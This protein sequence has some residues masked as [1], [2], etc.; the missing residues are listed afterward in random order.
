MNKEQVEEMYANIEGTRIPTELIPTCPKCGK[1][2]KPWVRSRVFLEG[3][4]YKSELGKYEEYLMKNKDKKVLFL[5]LGVGPM[6]P[7]CIKEPFWEMTGSWPNAF[8]ISINPKDAIVPKE[9]TGK[10]LAINEDI[11]RVF[12]DALNKKAK[13]EGLI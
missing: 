7:M 4:F 9:L 1:D 3:T 6:T 12:Q 5:E 13:R 11:A 10:G 2:M 8:Y